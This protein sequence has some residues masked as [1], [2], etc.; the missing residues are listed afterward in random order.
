MWYSEYLSRLQ[1]RSK[2][3]REQENVRPGQLVLLRDEQ[4]SPA[5]WPVAKV[6]KV[7][8]GD[9]DKVRVVKLVKHTASI[10][11]PIPKDFKKYVAKLKTHRSILK[12][13]ISRV[14]VLPVEESQ[15]CNGDH[16]S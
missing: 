4:T 13:P 15:L 8:P 14:S 11:P 1:Q 2:W 5:K 3:L 7:Y 9:D 12:R 10:E 6:L 16:S